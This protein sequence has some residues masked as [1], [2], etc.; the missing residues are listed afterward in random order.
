VRF[1]AMGDMVLI[2]VIL[3]ALNARFGQPV[4]IVASGSWTEPLLRGQPGVGDIFTIESRR[5]PY[6]L[7]LEQRR[8]VARLRARGAGPTW[9]CESDD[10]KPRAFLARAGYDPALLVF[11]ND[12]PRKPGEHFAG[13]WLR[14]ASYTPS[15]LPP[16]PSVPES[17]GPY[18]VLQV[19]DAM[20]TECERWLSRYAL[21]EQAPILVQA[22]NKRTMRRG[23][24]QRSSNTKYWPEERWAQVLRGLRERHPDQPIFLLGVPQEAALNDE[25]LKLAAIDGAHNIAADLSTSPI[26]RLLA[27][28]ERAQGMISVD[29]GPGHAA[30]AVGCPVVTLFGKAEPALY[31]PRGPK[32]WTIPV[33]GVN[34]GE[35]SMLGISPEDVL[36]AWDRLKE[37]TDLR[38]RA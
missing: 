15:A 33:T 4:D 24:R 37:R 12:C 22:G 7:S 23:S 11:S 25:V 26:P 9:I 3:R 14:F 13:R 35:P 10:V 28:A 20:R 31:V 8:L 21:S 36:T 17:I 27:L 38:R 16:A 29:S 30:A 18:C 32:P 2:T 34:D 1:G 19:T 5:T 6:W